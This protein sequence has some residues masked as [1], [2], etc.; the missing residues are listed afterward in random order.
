MQA[1]NSSTD[2]AASAL[3]VVHRFNEAFAR[4]NVDAVMQLMTDDCRFENTSPPP[5]GE[6][7]VGQ[8][9]VRKFWHDFFA[10]TEDA[11]FETEEIFAA[12]DRVVCRWRFTWGAPSAEGHV[13][14]VDVFRVR[15][16]KVAEKLSYVKG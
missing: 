2:R 16:G 11:R 8:A 6:Q 1:A 7:H 3:A 10:S 12:D 9:A 13:R 14:G 15:D 5:D 4:R